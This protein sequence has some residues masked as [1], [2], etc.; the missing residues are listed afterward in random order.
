MSPRGRS[1]A[2]HS[3]GTKQTEA[4]RGGGRLASRACVCVC[5]ECWREGAHTLSYWS[6]KTLSFSFFFFFFFK[7]NLEETLATLAFVCHLRRD[8]CTE[9]ISEREILPEKKII[10]TQL[11]HA[12]SAVAAVKRGVRQADMQACLGGGE[13]LGHRACCQTA[14]RRAIS[15]GAPPWRWP[16]D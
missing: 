8:N 13:A 5:V 14:P 16:S 3:T 10:K 15:A 9:L 11:A 4:R 6:M 1:A 2:H 7:L 12:S